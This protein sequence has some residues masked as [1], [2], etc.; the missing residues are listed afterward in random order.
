MCDFKEEFKKFAVY[1][2]GLNKNVVDGYVD[3]FKNT[4]RT[5]IEE[6]N[7]NFR[8]IDNFSRLI[9]DRIIFLGSEINDNIANI[10]VAELLF[11]ESI[12]RKADIRLYINSPGGEIYSG[13]SIYDTM[14]NID[15]DVETICT[16]LAASMAAV[17]L[18]GGEKG[19]RYALKH[20][21]VMIHQPLGGTKGQATDMEI[22]VNEIKKLKKEI[23][24]I[25][26]EHTGK[27][28]EEIAK[29]CERDF[30]MTSEEAMKYGLIDKILD[31][32]REK[33]GDSVGEDSFKI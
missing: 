17:L 11:L 4:T 9:M 33:K 14:Q 30:W 23:G 10:V 16:G 7:K 21:R 32:K 15:P 3:S 1:D 13:L 27:N 20:S 28:I 26:V 5:V 24:E 22:T 8:E 31:K 12:D 6:R 2:R 18:A 29:D 19:K 25:L